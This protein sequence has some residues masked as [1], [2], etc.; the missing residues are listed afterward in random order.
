MYQQTTGAR[1]YAN[2]DTH[3]W[4]RE[5]Q[6]FPV[7]FHVSASGSRLYR[8]PLGARQCIARLDCRL[9][10]TAL[11]LSSTLQSAIV[12][13]LAL[14]PLI[15]LAH[16]KAAFSQLFAHFRRPGKAKHRSHPAVNRL[17]SPWLKLYLLSLIELV[18]VERV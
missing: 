2:T 1:T 16:Y 12:F 14:H 17:A 5:P 18:R 13:C 8:D 6:R 4:L 3:I 9:I 11:P 10:S 15:S 7:V